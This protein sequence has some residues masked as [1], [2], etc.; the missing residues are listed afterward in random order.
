MNPINSWIAYRQ[1]K[2]QAQLRLFCFPY[3]GGSAAIYRTWAASLPTTVEVCP[4]QLPGR[5]NRLTEPA[6]ARMEPLLDALLPALSPYLDRPFALFGHSMG[7]AIAY[8]AAQRLR[9][10]CSLSPQHLLVSARRAPH[11]PDD[12]PPVYALPEPQ[13]KAKLRALSGTPEAVLNHPGLMELLLPLV[14]RDFELNDTYA[15]L[16][17]PPLECPI[18]VFGGWDDSEVRRPHLEAWRQTTWGGFQ[19]RM[20]PGDHFFVHTQSLALLRAVAETL[21]SPPVPPTTPDQS[22]TAV[23]PWP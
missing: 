13:F 15:P 17:Q 11:L 19:L 2:P 8:E 14:R 10:E 4:V 18:T 20:L 12:E 7:A 6:F 16:A 1:P 9:A 5:E 21:V 22:A 23:E 3:A